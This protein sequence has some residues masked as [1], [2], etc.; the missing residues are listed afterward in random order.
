V[1]FGVQKQTVGALSRA[2]FGLDQRSGTGEP[3]N[4]KLDQN[5]GILVF[6]LLHVGNTIFQTWLNLAWKNM[7][8]V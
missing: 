5:Y 8:Q 2:G 6:F 7:S 3:Q 1:T 4:S